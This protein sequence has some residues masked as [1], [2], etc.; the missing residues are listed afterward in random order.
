MI[1]PFDHF[2][3]PPASYLKKDIQG[4]VTKNIYHIVASASLSRFEAHV[5]LFKL[6][7]KGIFDP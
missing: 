6:L 1:T 5:G 3:L 4:D 2:L 7:M